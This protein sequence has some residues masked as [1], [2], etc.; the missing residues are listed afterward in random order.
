MVWH[1]GRIFKLKENGVSDKILN[2]ITDFL[3]FRKRVIWEIYN[4]MLG[5]Y[6]RLNQSDLLQLSKDSVERRFR[7]NWHQKIDIQRRKVQYMLHEETKETLVKL[8][9]YYGLN[10]T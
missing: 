6:E 10:C 8:Y 1:K 4:A 2:I 3:S 9:S 7:T 5:Q